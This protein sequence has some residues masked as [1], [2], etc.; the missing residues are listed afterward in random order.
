[1][2]RW[3]HPLRFFHGAWLTSSWHPNKKRKNIIPVWNQCSWVLWLYNQVSWKFGDVVWWG[4]P[5][6]DLTRLWFIRGVDHCWRNRQKV[7]KGVKLYVARQLTWAL[8]MLT[9]PCVLVS[10]PCRV[11]GYWDARAFPSGFLLSANWGSGVAGTYPIWSWY[12]A[13][14]CLQI[15]D[16]G[17]ILG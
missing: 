5:L 4:S 6:W 8:S 11:G 3:H 9:S 15:W 12:T 10:R 14:A 1:M 17:S 16:L 13:K 2:T 7:R